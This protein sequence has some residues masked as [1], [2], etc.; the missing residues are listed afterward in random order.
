[1]PSPK[2]SSQAVSKLLIQ[3]GQDGLSRNATEIL[4]ENLTPTTLAAA[5]G[6][7]I[8]DLVGDQVTLVCVVLDKTGSMDPHRLEVVEAYNRMLEALRSSKAAD[9]ILLSAWF[10]DEKSQLYH[11]F[12]PLGSCLALSRN[13]YFPDGNTA[14]FDAVLDS[15]TGVVAYAQE[16]KN[17]GILTK[18][19]VV[20]VTDG[21][22]NS[23]RHRASEVKVIAESLL[24]QEIYTLAL[25]GFGSGIASR[26]ARDMGFPNFLEA[27]ADASS[28][29]RAMNTVS[30]SVI[31]ASQTTINPNQSNSFF[32]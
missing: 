16:L 21:D 15:F 17:H 2:T 14:L 4:V 11:S 10:F 12:L 27:D 5:Q 29:R 7:S 18:A 26:A 6:T 20:A 9:S 13:N 23:S 8:D 24:R 19:V 1:M 30:K 22:D 3:A 32:S 25:V 31:R 28:I